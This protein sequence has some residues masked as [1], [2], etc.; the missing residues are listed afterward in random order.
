[1]G[2]KVKFQNSKSNRKALVEAEYKVYDPHCTFNRK[3]WIIIGTDGLLYG[4][5]RRNFPVVNVEEFL[6][7]NK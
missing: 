7:E 6:G 5:D 2:A 3:A 4:V 1:M